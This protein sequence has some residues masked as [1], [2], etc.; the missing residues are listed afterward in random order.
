VRRGN[1]RS[2][3]RM[4]VRRGRGSVRAG[5]VRNDAEERRDELIS[6][7]VV[8]PLFSLEA[9]VIADGSAQGVAVVLLRPVDRGQAV[10]GG[11]LRGG[12]GR[13][14]EDAEVVH[15]VV[16]GHAGRSRSR[17]RVHIVRGG[18]LCR[19]AGQ[20]RRPVVARHPPGRRGEG[21][22]GMMMVVA[23]ARGTRSCRV[24]DFSWRSVK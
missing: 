18:V 1:A 9:Q 20:I 23:V 22:R 12:G 21:V 5:R 15:C 19:Q 6:S 10:V 14:A 13:L 16:V 4:Q 24:P 2:R 3:P 11:V 7:S 8:I 17:S